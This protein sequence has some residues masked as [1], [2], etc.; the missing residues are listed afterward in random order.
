MSLG[1]K[2]NKIQK[3]THKGKQIKK[4]AKNGK[5]IFISAVSF[6]IF[7]TRGARPP[8]RVLVSRG[9]PVNPDNRGGAIFPPGEYSYNFPHN[10][11]A[12]IYR[13]SLSG[14]G[15]FDVPTE[16]TMIFQTSEFQAIEMKFKKLR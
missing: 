9:A 3:L 14:E 16:S 1:Y 2:G 6:S 8:Q 11:T 10:I 15:T 7:Y 13:Q 4:L 5:L 12:E